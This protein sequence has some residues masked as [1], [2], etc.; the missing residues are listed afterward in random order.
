MTQYYKDI[1]P[2]H[3]PYCYKIV[4]NKLYAYGAEG[5]CNYPVS[6]DSVYYKIFLRGYFERGIIEISKQEAFLELL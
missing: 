5:W 4:E 3:Y 2:W 1:Q 6:P